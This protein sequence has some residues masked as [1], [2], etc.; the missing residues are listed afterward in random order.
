MYRLGVQSVDKLFTVSVLLLHDFLAAL[1]MD[2]T[3]YDIAQ[4]SACK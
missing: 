4:S 3:A 2:S 1:L